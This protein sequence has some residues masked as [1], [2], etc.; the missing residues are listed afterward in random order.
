MVGAAN[1]AGQG[2][3]YLSKFAEKVTVLIRGENL[4]VHMSQYLVD[5]LDETPNIEVLAHTHVIEA[6]GTDHLEQLVLE[7]LETKQTETVPGSLLFIFIGA[8]PE[9]P[10]LEGVVASDDHGY[11]LTG[12]D[13]LEDNQ[14]PADW[15]LERHPFHLETSS[16]GIFATGDVRH[17]SIR[18]V[19][20]AVG[21]GSTAIQ[22]VHR[23]LAAIH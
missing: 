1:S 10:W 6:I 21:E 7:N 17:G 18:R 2:A 13:L 23:Y 8:E 3:K 11:I 19:A 20:G 14:L 22:L 16:P 4:G 5:Q 12:P 9:H 15:P